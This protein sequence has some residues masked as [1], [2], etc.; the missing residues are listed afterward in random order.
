[1]E[2]LVINPINHIQNLN[3]ENYKMLMKEV[4]E[5][6]NK[7]KS[8]CSEIR[9]LNIIKVSIFPKLINRFKAILI[10]IPEGYLVDVNKL[11]L[12]LI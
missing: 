10:K 2:Y 12:K 3:V 11:M 7:R 8:L 1:M 6:L 9:R 4:K 5:N